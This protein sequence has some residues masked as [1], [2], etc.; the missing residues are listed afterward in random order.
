MFVGGIQRDFKILNAYLGG[1][2]KLKY[3]NM[4]KWKIKLKGSSKKMQ[5]EKDLV[6]WWKKDEF[7]LKIIVV[8]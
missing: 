4:S 1:E 3:W 7:G 6:R 8:G 5:N 2:E